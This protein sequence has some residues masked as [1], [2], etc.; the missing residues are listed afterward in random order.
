MFIKKKETVAMILAGGQGSRLYV[1]TGKIAKPAVPFGGKHRLIDFTISNCVNSGF[2][3]VGVLT[4]Y[5]PLLL[6][7][8]IGNGQPWDLDRLEGGLTILPPYQKN[9]GADWY[10]GSANAVFQNMHY[11]DR[12]DPEYV[13]VLGA[14]HV[15]KMDYSEILRMHKEKKADCTLAV[16]E[17]PIEEASRFGIMNMNPDGRI[18]EFEEKPKEP[19]SN[20][21]SMGMYIFNWQKLRKFLIADNEDENSAKDFGKNII[22]AMLKA[23]EK[24]YAYTFK[25]YWRDVGTIESLWQANMD[26]LDDEYKKD[27]SNWKV[28][29][30]TMGNPPHYIGPTGSIKNS[31]ISEGSEIYGTVEHSIIFPG[32]KVQEGAYVRD[33][34]IMAN[35]VIKANTNVEY[36]IIDENVVVG[37]NSKIGEEREAASG[38][39]VI[40]KDV[41][42]A[43]GV[44]IPANQMIDMNIT[45]VG[46]KYIESNH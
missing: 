13:C 34:I 30:R 1:L 5:Q 45:T 3:T 15:Y 6:N 41:E 46:A 36:S 27:L 37:C 39:T 25:G 2:D 16:I 19:K 20:K 42:I 31:I 8:Y 14:D 38:I 40:A 35:S 29:S 43:D 11:L 17:V 9:Q 26:L 4:Q 18:Y 10:S 12:Y 44:V 32:V 7:E 28:Y 22:P 23:G 24:M 21:A 33:S